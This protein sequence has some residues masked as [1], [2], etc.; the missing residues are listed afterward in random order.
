[1][2][3][4]KELLNFISATLS[5]PFLPLNLITW[6]RS[7]PYYLSPLNLIPS[8]S[9]RSLLFPFSL[10]LPTQSHTRPWHALAFPPPFHTHNVH[11]PWSQISAGKQTG[12]HAQSATDCLERTQATWP[13]HLFT[14]P[15]Y[16]PSHF[17][18]IP[19]PLPVSHHPITILFQH[20]LQ[21]PH[22]TPS[23]S[24][25]RIPSLSLFPMTVAP[26]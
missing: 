23:Q 1:M 25:S 24:V 12:C 11:S 22:L 7:Y 6:L 26:I 3:D 5:Q 13:S 8:M 15:I 4:S 16:T 19:F 20:I 21:P 14:Q 2:V 17:K 10:S 18:T 9:L